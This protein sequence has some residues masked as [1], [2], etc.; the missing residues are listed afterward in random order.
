MLVN[1]AHLPGSFSRR[2]VAGPGDT[3]LDCTAGN[4]YDSL[5]MA[6][7]VALGDGVGKLYVMDVQASAQVHEDVCCD[8]GSTFRRK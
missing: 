6:K 1:F 2:Q 7:I 5:E 8:R 3:V 4:G